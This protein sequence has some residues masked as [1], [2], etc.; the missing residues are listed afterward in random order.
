MQLTMFININLMHEQ[1][2]PSVWKCYK[3]VATMQGHIWMPCVCVTMPCKKNE[4]YFT[5]VVQ[6]STFLFEDTF[7]HNFVATF[8][9]EALNHHSKTTNQIQEKHRFDMEYMPR[10]TKH[11]TSVPNP[12]ILYVHA[13]F[14]KHLI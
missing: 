5:L 9:F 4:V 1:T 2:L 13:S 7:L 11:L 14:C 3:N 6:C 12:Y 8:F 10:Q